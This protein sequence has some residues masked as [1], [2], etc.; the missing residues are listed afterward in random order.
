MDVS[1]SFDSRPGML[2][3]FTRGL[4]TLGYLPDDIRINGDTVS[5]LFDRPKSKQPV[6]DSAFIA[7]TQKKN[8][9]MVDA[10]NGVK[11]ELNLPDNSPGSIGKMLEQAP[12]LLLNFLKNR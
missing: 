1:I 11:R 10:Y 7:L 6:T 4:K 3:P 5:L 8:K 9:E 12:D 2:E